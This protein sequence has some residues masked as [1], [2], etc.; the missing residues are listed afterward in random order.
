M[1]STIAP[2][3]VRR[4]LLATG[5]EDAP[6]GFLVKYASQV[7]LFEAMTPFDLDREIQSIATLERSSRSDVAAR[8]GMLTAAEMGKPVGGTVRE[9]T[10]YFAIVAAAGVDPE[11]WEKARAA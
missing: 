9:R 1:R 10:L 3:L 2:A 4:Y 8:L 7:G 6:R 11:A 5:W